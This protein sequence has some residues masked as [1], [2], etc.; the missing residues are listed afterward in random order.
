MIYRQLSETYG[1]TPDQI[2]GL[3]MFQLSIYL[4]GIGPEHGRMKMSPEDAA[5]YIKH[6]Q[7]NK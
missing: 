6:V 3:T 2:N 4:G 1:F 5:A 7:E